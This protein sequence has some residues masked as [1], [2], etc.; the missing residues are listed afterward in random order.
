MTRL[1]LY[2]FTHGDK[3]WYF[4]SARKA[5][6]HNNITY[7]PVK[8]L[9]RG[10][11]EDAD[12]DKAEIE[13]TFPQPYSLLN[14]DEQS[15]SQ[16]FVNKIFYQGVKVE[17]FELEEDT[18]LFVFRGRVVKPSFDENDDTMTLSCATA[19][20][21][22]RRT[23]FTQK[24]QR[25]CPYSIYDLFCG[26]DISEWS[27][28]ARIT[29]LSGTAFTF[30]VL[31]T[32]VKDVEGNPVFEQVPLLDENDDPVFDENNNPI[33]V[34]GDP[35]MEVKS[36]PYGYLSNGLLIK[37]GVYTWLRDNY[38]MYRSHFGLAVGDVVRLAPGCDQSRKMCHEKFDNH[39]RFG[40]HINIPS[41][42]PVDTQIIK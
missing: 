27:F 13:I 21:Q 24:F 17:I 5:I 41:E 39:I 42:N 34:N 33:R 22:F 6:T 26:L 37:D 32:Q 3:Q 2:Q 30:E 25:T 4:T 7:Y 28:E 35:V 20:T 23:I 14:K 10:N 31:P 38:T 9:S 16:I 36:Y 40:G 29:S 15:L 8:G 12:I 19:E 1:E 11:I 18:Q